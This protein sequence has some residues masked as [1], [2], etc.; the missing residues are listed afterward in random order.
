MA[1]IPMGNFG[2][3]VARPGPMATIPRGDAVGQAADR[4]AQIGGGIVNDMA[5]QET[6]QA[7]EAK[8]AAIRVRTLT[9]LNGTKDQL[10]D[11]HDQIANGVLDGSVPKEKAEA[12]YNEG[13]SKTLQGI[14]ADLPDENRQIVMAELGS[15]AARLGNNVR[16]V[17]TQRDRQDVTSGINQTLEYLQRQYAVDPGKATQQAMDTVDQLGPHSNLSPDQ[18]GKLK[19]TWK[20]G[21]QFT[22]AYT[23]VSQGRNDRKALDQ[24]ETA[25]VQGF[26][27]LDPQ[28]RAT[29]LDRTQAYRLH[30]DQKDEMAAARAQREA[31]RRL[32]RA[33]AEFNVFEKMAD[34]GTVLDPSYIDQAIAATTGTPY[35]RGIVAMANQARENGGLAAQPITA[36][37]QTLDQVNA[38]I[39]QR[40]RTPEL[41]KRKD[42]IE[43]VLRGSE[44]DIDKD[45]LRAGLERGVITDLK[46]LDLTKGMPGVIQQLT[47][48]VPL[49]QRV[50]VWA[51]RSVSPMTE[52]E[53]AQL[54]HQLDTLP[55]KDRSGMV[56]A[57]AQ[58][59]G[60]QQAQ[61]LATQMD[62][63]DKGLALAF[64][65][66][67][68]STTAGRY[69]SELVLKGQQ[70]KLD[71]TSTK[72][73]KQPDVKVAQW[74]ANI[75]SQLDGLF[76]A[77]TLTN[78][79]REAALLIAHGLS[80]E[81]GGQLREKDLDRAVG[82][83]IGGTIV[84]HNG[85]KVP[86]PAGVDEDMLDK[87]L[88][89]ISP[90]ELTKQAPE[91]VVRAGG[92]PVSVEEFTK[93]LPG[94]QLMYAGPGRFAVIVGGRPVLNGQGKPILIGVQ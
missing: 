92:V 73:E 22:T 56:A 74:S 42:A 93:T 57:L 82:F 29:L 88:R 83:A 1:T 61:R 11:L 86:L 45:P 5:A 4:V 12:T 49:A 66:A 48:R 28:K 80:A 8:Q 54:K 78:Q 47:D 44:S 38:E 41:D 59:V 21:T 69:T 81:A 50:G 14:G 33:E 91:G 31:E 19:Q 32:K 43:K 71:G 60:P 27:D 53:A 46:P 64:A 2:Q 6:K 87:R 85:R 23:M 70:A 65:F 68:A 35:Q 72:N 76:P 16:K 90:A 13:V 40:G 79:T 52:D 3:A 36:Q 63:K 58:A 39:A 17:V 77:Q 24:A 67:G 15:D 34:K 62:K 25:I 94:Q 26:P 20:E 9:T 84:E 7:M 10:A 89:S 30:L 75:A 51:G 18:L 55:A 37:R